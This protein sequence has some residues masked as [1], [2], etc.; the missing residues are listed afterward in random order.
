LP[1]GRCPS[2]GAVGVEASLAW[3]GVVDRSGVG[4][5]LQDRPG[6]TLGGGAGARGTDRKS[7]HDGPARRLDGSMPAL[8][9]MFQTVEAPVW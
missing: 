6:L 7:V 9:R 3:R 4:D 2:E 5:D 1:D 8:F